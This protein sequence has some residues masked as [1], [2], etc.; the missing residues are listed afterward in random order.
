[1]GQLIYHFLFSLWHAG[2][3]YALLL[4]GRSK[5]WGFQVTSSQNFW[6]FVACW[7]WHENAGPNTY[8][9]IHYFC[10]NWNFYF[11]FFSF[12]IVDIFQ[13]Y[14]GSQL[15][16]TA[17]CVQAIISTNLVEEFGPTLRNAH[18][19]LKKS[20]VLSLLVR[21]Y[22]IFLICIY[23][24]SPCFDLYPAVV[25]MFLKVLEDCPGNLDYWYRHISKGAWPFSTADHGW[26]IS[27]CTAEG[28]KVMV[29]VIKS[30]ALFSLF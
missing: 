3:K 25:W 13:G 20:Q 26:P 21:N 17:F 8:K 16:D 14:N 7:R 12:D 2:F 11:I 22:S 27:D 23:C 18:T 29:T 15:W 6:L 4:G 5:L 19:F 1:M 28:L 24:L 10:L 30:F 9:S